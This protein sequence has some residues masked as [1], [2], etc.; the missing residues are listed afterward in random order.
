MIHLITGL[1]GNGKTLFTL[2]TVKALAEKENR[3]VY[4]ARIKG[5]KLPWTLID[6]FE[7]YRCPAGSIVVIDECQRSDDPSDPKSPSL[8]GVRKRG[9]TVPR[10]A[11]ELETH[12][13]L[14]I[15]L[16]LVTQHPM[17]LHLNVRRLSNRHVHL[18]RLFGSQ[19]SRVFQWATVQERCDKD[20]AGAEPTFFAF[21]SD[22]F[23]LYK[24]AE[25]HTVKRRI[26]PVIF[27]VFAL[28]VIVIG[29]FVLAFAYKPGAKDAAASKP[30]QAAIAPGL[31]ASMRPGTAQALAAGAAV[32]T[33]AQYVEQFTP[34]VAGLHY[35]APA[36][37]GLTTPT[38]VPYPAACMQSKGRC[39]CYTQQ[40]TELEVSANLCAAIV[41][42]GFFV[43]WRAPK[44]D[45]PSQDRI[46]GGPGTGA[47]GP[48]MG[49]T[50]IQ[51]A[52]LP[53]QRYVSDDGRS[54]AELAV[55]RRSLANGR[56][57]PALDQEATRDNVYRANRAGTVN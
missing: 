28:P 27:A 15:D 48:G 11:A 53:A 44:A 47:A 8:F 52:P 46:S 24:S 36:Y 42:K 19:K 18:F 31:L 25:V 12:R 22:V 1:P 51:T 45:P 5:L 29:L 33:P 7:W 16:V 10:W 3:P 55:L 2:A 43:A 26:P 30:A 13:H 50:P 37:D 34:R 17:L 14:G 57:A 20:Q 9:E 56:S 6:P 4:Y 21:P 41:S 35:T 32:A 38:E 40:A 23:E 39:K 54:L 49:G